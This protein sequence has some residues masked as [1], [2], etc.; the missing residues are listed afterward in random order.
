V[1]GGASV[2]TPVAAGGRDDDRDDDGREE[3]SAAVAV[4]ASAI[5][6]G[7]VTSRDD[8]L[9]IYGAQKCN[10]A[11]RMC[12]VCAGAQKGSNEH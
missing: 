4:A 8:R 11:M 12:E 2:A 1:A 7:A 3:E 5:V 10:G 6:G 9:D